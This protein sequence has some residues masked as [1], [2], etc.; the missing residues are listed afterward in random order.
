LHNENEQFFNT[1]VCQKIDFSLCENLHREKKVIIIVRLFLSVI[2][3]KSY[4]NI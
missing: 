4:E 1:V 2:E 3:K